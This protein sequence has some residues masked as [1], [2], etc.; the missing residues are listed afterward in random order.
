M[1]DGVRRGAP[2]L[3]RRRSDV[4]LV[5]VSENDRSMPCG[6]PLP[7]LGLGPYVFQDDSPDEKPVDGVYAETVEVGV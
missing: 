6:P 5:A 3:E 2:G 4:A 1:L 7:P